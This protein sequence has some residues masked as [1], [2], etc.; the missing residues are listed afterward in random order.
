MSAIKESSSLQDR[1]TRQQQAT[2]RAIGQSALTKHAG[3]F[4]MTLIYVLLHLQE[5]PPKVQTMTRNVTMIY[6]S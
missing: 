2:S 1:F 6:L 5:K 3:C 4:E